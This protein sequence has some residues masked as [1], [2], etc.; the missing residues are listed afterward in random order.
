MSYSADEINRRVDLI[1]EIE[2][3]NRFKSDFNPKN[4]PEINGLNHSVHLDQIFEIEN[5]I[6]ENC[7]LVKDLCVVKI[8]N[9]MYNTFLSIEVA[10]DDADEEEGGDE[11]N[12]SG[13]AGHG[14]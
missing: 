4:S 2:H 11:A 8:K 1:N 3:A 12:E 6:I 5:S 14:C 10:L 13:T 9:L 7:Q